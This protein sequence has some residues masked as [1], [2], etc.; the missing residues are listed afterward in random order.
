VYTLN[1]LLAFD[2][3]DAL[4]NLS[5][6]RA[7][8]KCI[9]AERMELAGH[10]L[11]LIKVFHIAQPRAKL[12]YGTEHRAKRR[13]RIQVIGCESLEAKW[14]VSY[15]W[16]TVTKTLYLA[17]F[18]RCDLLQAENVVSTYPTLGC[19][20]NLTKLPFDFLD[21][22]RILSR[23]RIILLIREIT[24]RLSQYVW[25]QSTNVTD[26]RTDDVPYV[27]PPRHAHTCFAQ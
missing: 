10:G 9:A 5:T 21:D 19:S 17:Q 6:W 12:C 1:N 11:T 16:F 2:A 26:R 18:L 13:Q 4:S 24:F 3:R 14:V 23:G 22:V 20:T 15:R 25:S 27:I 7:A 8:V